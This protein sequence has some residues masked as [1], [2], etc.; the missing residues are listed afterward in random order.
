MIT[1]TGKKFHIIVNTLSV[2]QLLNKTS[3]KFHT[4]PKLIPDIFERNIQK[5]EF[6]IG[7]ICAA[8][9]M[10]FVLCKENDYYQNETIKNINEI[11]STATVIQRQKQ[12]HTPDLQNL[13]NAIAHGDIEPL[14]NNVFSFINKRGKKNNDKLVFT[15]T[16]ESLTKIMNLAINDLKLQLNNIN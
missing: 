10:L 1:G 16:A 15:L 7:S 13:R 3:E 5:I 2:V 4:N 14:E 8:F 12:N 9:Y 11:I 6:Q